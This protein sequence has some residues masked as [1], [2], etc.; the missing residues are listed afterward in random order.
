[1]APE[2]DEQLLSRVRDMIRES[3]ARQGVILGASVAQLR[4]QTDAQRRYDLA[5]V[6]AGLSY[7]EGKTGLQ[8]ARTTE[9]MGHVL[10]ATQKR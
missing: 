7:L 8:V 5:Q 6:G 9:L 4:D 10:Q 2:R 1:M 3:E